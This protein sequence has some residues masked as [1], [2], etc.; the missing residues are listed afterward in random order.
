MP[1]SGL[2]AHH[3]GDFHIFKN[4]TSAAGFFKSNRADTE[5]LLQRLQKEKLILTEDWERLSDTIQSALTRHATDEEMLL[6]LLVEHGLITEYQAGRI[7][8]G[9]TFGLILGNYRVLERIGAGGMGIVFKAEHIYMRRMAAIKVLPLGSEDNS[10]V[11]QR[12]YSEMRMVAQL[13][14]PNIVVAFDAGRLDHHEPYGQS[15]L[16]FVMEYLEG[17]DLEQFVDRHGPMPVIQAC[18]IMHQI[19]SALLEAHKHKLV[20]RDIK[21]SN[22]LVTSE[23]QAKLLDFGLAR[24]FDSRLTDPGTVLGTLDYLSPEQAKDASTV[25]IRTDIYGLGGTLFWCLT[26]EPPFPSDG[27]MVQD[28]ARR[29]NQPPPSVRRHQPEISQELDDIIQRM[30][31]TD[32]EDRFPT[33]EA[34]QQALL[35]FLRPDS[36]EHLLFAREPV[37][38]IR[39]L[40]VSEKDSSKTKF[41]LPEN[42]VKQILIVDDEKGI[43]DFCRFTLQ[44][45]RIHCESVNDGVE[46]LEALETRPYDL[47]LLDINMPRMTGTELLACLREK[48]TLA[49][50]KIILFSGHQTPDEMS[51][52]LACNVDDFLTKPFSVIQLKS[53]VHAALRLK[54]AQDRSDLLTHHLVTMNQELE[55]SLNARDSDLVHARN[56]LVL[57]LAQMVEFKEDEN[58]AHLLRMQH[59]CRA[60]A[61]EAAAQPEFSEKIDEAFIRLL[62]CCA[63]LH[64]IG[65]VALPDHIVLKPGKLEPEERLLMQTHTTLGADILRRVAE[66]Y[67]SALAFL[68][69]AIDIACYHHERYDGQGY[70][71]GLA[72]SDIPLAARIVTVAD[73]Y[74]ALRTPRNYK[75]ALS[76]NTALQVMAEISSGQFDPLLL[77]AFKR[78]APQFEQIFRKYP[79]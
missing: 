46:A 14:H 15:L 16:Y 10:V 78:C 40:T 3:A 36:P 79:S 26:G 56:S 59:Y 45:E 31:A 43:C 19:A 49:K 24:C 4:G 37:A 48:R 33:P 72:G 39:Q 50:M 20:H 63:P 1:S 25:D 9:T 64:D 35:P 57:A 75:P 13:L 71:D 28:L 18:D 5:N 77:Q 22:I 44:S 53:R 73:V 51:L 62:E 30:M 60:L 69:M 32:P 68:N 58:G 54:E 67:G 42:R 34:V 70:P 76:H 23:Q 66:Q 17:H 65:K 55:K 7:A 61:E 6:P 27:N 47:M 74:D 41:I 8:A 2:S 29:L 52:L 12:F 11:L 21:P 38:P